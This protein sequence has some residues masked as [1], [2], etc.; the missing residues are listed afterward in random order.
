MGMGRPINHLGMRE[1]AILFSGQGMRNGRRG[2]QE[3]EKRKLPDTP[4][5]SDKH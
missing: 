1:R 4:L 2:E 5:S 3:E